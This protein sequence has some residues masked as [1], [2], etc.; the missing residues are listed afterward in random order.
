P[1]G[2]VHELIDE[3][4]GLANGDRQDARR[5][6]VQGAGVADFADARGAP[7]LPY[8]VERGHTPRLVDVEEASD[9]RGELTC[10]LYSRQDSRAGLEVPALGSRHVT[11]HLRHAVA[12]FDGLVQLKV[13]RGDAAQ[14]HLAVDLALEELRRVSERLEHLA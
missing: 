5:V 14:L 6:R 4:R 7:Y 8:D 10:A 9:H 3:P 11:Q 12:L 2:G 1:L 13:E